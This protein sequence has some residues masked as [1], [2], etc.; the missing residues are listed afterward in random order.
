MQSMETLKY[1]LFKKIVMLFGLEKAER[2]FIFFH[3]FK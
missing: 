3:L 2:I 1:R